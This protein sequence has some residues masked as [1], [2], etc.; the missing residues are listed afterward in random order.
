MTS[1]FATP[2]EK[3][4]KFIGDSKDL[5]IYLTKKVKVLRE[6][7]KDEKDKVRKKKIADRIELV[8]EMLDQ[9]YFT[10]DRV[11]T[12]PELIEAIK[13]ERALLYTEYK[14]MEPDLNEAR[15]LAY[16]AFK[17]AGGYLANKFEDKNY[18]TKEQVEAREFINE[19][20]FLEWEY[21]GLVHLWNMLWKLLGVI[22]RPVGFFDKI[23]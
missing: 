5:R 13:L 18:N 23:I 2:N 9:K 10:E 11:Y 6:L 19:Y 12:M 22:N 16:D 20:Q 21:E 8:E 17:K 14:S 15:K 7:L 4:G 1:G 3:E